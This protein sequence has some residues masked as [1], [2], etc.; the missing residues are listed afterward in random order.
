M[1]TRQPRKDGDMQRWF[2]CAWCVRPSLF[3]FNVNFIL[4]TRANVE[5]ENVRTGER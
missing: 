4:A 5:L 1:V 2:T 3:N